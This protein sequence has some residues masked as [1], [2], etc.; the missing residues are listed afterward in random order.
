MYFVLCIVIESSVLIYV[1]IFYV[2]KYFHIVCFYIF[3]E[4]YPFQSIAT[5]SE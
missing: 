2:T 5:I 3:R 4:H 1:L